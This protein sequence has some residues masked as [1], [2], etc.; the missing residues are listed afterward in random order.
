MKSPTYHRKYLFKMS[1]IHSFISIFI[2]RQGLSKAM[3]HKASK[4]KEKYENFM[5]ENGTF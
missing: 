3:V 4:P 2:W 5:E 1:E